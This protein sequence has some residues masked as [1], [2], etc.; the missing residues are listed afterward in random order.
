MHWLSWIQSG[1]PLQLPAVLQV[2]GNHAGRLSAQTEAYHMDL[3]QREQF[4]VHHKIEELRRAISHHLQVLHCVEVARLER[5]RAVV[6][7]ND[8]EFTVLEESRSNVIIGSEVLVACIAV[9][10]N[11]KRP[12]GY[13]VR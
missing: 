6:N 11:N 5:Q 1:D 3:F 10:K 13:V 9:D 7:G 4:V 2:I 12:P 8:I